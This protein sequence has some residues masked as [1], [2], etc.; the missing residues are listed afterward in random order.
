MNIYVISLS[1]NSKLFLSILLLI[2]TLIDR[3]II[4]KLLVLLLIY[5]VKKFYCALVNRQGHYL[6]IIIYNV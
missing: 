4:E 1:H 3:F 6:G 5:T 2:I